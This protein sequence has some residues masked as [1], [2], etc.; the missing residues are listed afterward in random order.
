MN[1]RLTCKSP[2][3]RLVDVPPP[4]GVDFVRIKKTVKE[5][6]EL[7]AIIEINFMRPVTTFREIKNKSTP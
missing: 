4:Q 3:F 1:D 7:A 6:S 2:L 5:E